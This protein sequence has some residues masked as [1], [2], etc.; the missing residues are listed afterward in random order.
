MGE[1]G[2][3]LACPMCHGKGQMHRSDI[4]EKLCDP[5]LG[6]K[7]QTYLQEITA[8]M[9]DREHVLEEAAAACGCEH[10]TAREREVLSW[11]AKKQFLWRRSPK[12]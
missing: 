4:L 3:Y 11:P 12:E 10:T 2:H 1:N 6:R 5:E 8:D 9:P 7:I